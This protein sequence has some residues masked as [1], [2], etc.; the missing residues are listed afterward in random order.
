MTL[1]ELIAALEAFRQDWSDLPVVCQVNRFYDQ[2]VTV[3]SVGVYG[4]TRAIGHP[5]GALVP[6]NPGTPTLCLYL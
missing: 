1:T 6:L 3:K 4:M 5:E 2:H